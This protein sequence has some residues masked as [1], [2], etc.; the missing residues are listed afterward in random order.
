PSSPAKNS[1]WP[2]SSDIVRALA[3]RARES[4]AG[5]AANR[6]SAVAGDFAIARPIPVTRLVY[7][8]AQVASH[9]LYLNHR[10]A[11]SRKP[12]HPRRLDWPP[13]E[14][15]PFVFRPT[16]AARP[17]RPR[18]SVEMRNRGDLDQ[19]FRSYQIGADAIAR[20]RVF[21]KVL[22]IHLVHGGVSAHIGEE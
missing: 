10:P 14:S 1:I 3:N 20:R 5:S 12:L 13:R 2:E 18:L 4:S 11:I 16:P 7:P 6:L 15:H 22:P 8:S 9:I 21:G 19:E 17:R